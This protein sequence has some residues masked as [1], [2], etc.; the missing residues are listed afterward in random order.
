[1]LEELVC[2]VA[3]ELCVP[4]LF[5]LVPVPEAADPVTVALDA[6]DVEPSLFPITPSNILFSSGTQ[7]H[8]LETVARTSRVHNRLKFANER[9][10]ERMPLWQNHI[11]TETTPKIVERQVS[12]K[13]SIDP[14]IQPSSHTDT[15][16]GSKRLGETKE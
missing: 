1:M 11:K 6:C 4:V 10:L 12:R 9:I 13:R 15:S 7:G 16:T 14:E 5:A 8:E 3:V 2:F